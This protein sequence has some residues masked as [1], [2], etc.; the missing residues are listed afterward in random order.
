MEGVNAMFVSRENYENY[1]LS[2]SEI[3]RG[4]VTEKLTTAAREIFAVVERTVSGYEEEAA[5]LR[6]EID[7]QRIQ[8]EALLQP[9][10]SLRRIDEP[11]CKEEAHWDGEVLKEEE[12]Q[13]THGEDLGTYDNFAH[14]EEDEAEDGQVEEIPEEAFGPSCHK[15]KRDEAY[16][17]SDKRSRTLKNRCGKRTNLNL[18]VC[19]LQ[20]SKVK[21]LKRGGRSGRSCAV[22]GCF[23]N[24]GKIQVWNKTECLEHK[25]LLHE[26][27]PCLRPYGL[28]RFPGRSKDAAVRQL[29]IKNINRKDFVPSKHSTVCGIHFKDGQPTKKHPYP[30]LHMGYEHHGFSSGRRPP[31]IR[32]LEPSI[33]NTCTEPVVM[34]SEIAVTKTE[35]L[36]NQPQQ[37]CEVGVQL[38]DAKDH[39]YCSNQSTTDSA[40]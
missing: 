13:L 27:C 28:H 4:I 3:L 20:D 39:T 7:R 21:K 22:I 6:Q 11:V 31:K 34:E 23:N 5:G 24:S 25:P 38:P 1:E 14:T 30:V 16:Q 32:R 9:R 18:R 12:E 40:T 8:L 33:V 10:V 29:W 36:E 37:K 15:D 17:I 26:E 2:K 19:L 35:D